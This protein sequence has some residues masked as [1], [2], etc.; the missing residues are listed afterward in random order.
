MNIIFETCVESL[1]GRAAISTRTTLTRLGFVGW[2]LG[3]RGGI[4]AMSQQSHGGN[5]LETTD[6]NKPPRTC[7]STGSIQ[8]RLGNVR[9]RLA[10]RKDLLLGRGGGGLFTREYPTFVVHK[11]PVHTNAFCFVFIL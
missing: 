8:A 2:R 10:T 1:D 5:L 6:C 3:R 11:V 7:S 4:L 9:D